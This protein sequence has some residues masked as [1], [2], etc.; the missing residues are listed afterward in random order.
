MPRDEER[1]KLILA[2]KQAADKS[3]GY[4]LR[5]EF[6]RLTGINASQI[7]R[8]FPEG[9]FTELLRLADIPD[10]PEMQKRRP[11]ATEEILEE[12]HRIFAELQRIPTRTLYDAHS[13]VSSGTT[14][15]RFGGWSKALLHIY[16]GW[17]QTILRHR[18][19]MIFDPEYQYRNLL[20]GRMAVRPVGI[21]VWMYPIGLLTG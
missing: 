6:V 19:S 7:Y 2:A 9:G 17:S 11:V 1:A 13:K 20:R 16:N 4:L 14:E 5:D 18:G 8:A 3:G 12:M 21:T 10:H 15:K